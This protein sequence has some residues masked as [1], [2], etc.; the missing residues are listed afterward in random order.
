[1]CSSKSIPSISSHALVRLHKAVGQLEK[2]IS[3]QLVN[4]CCKREIG[5]AY[6]PFPISYCTRLSDWPKGVYQL[7]N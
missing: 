4:R 7:A 6:G 2:Q 1:M 3:K 5:V